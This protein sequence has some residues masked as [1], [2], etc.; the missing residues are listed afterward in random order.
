M[1]SYPSV[2][3]FTASVWRTYFTPRPVGPFCPSVR[4][5][6]SSF[7]CLSSSVLQVLAAVTNGDAAALR[8]CHT[9]RSRCSCCRRAK[10]ADAHWPNLSC[11]KTSCKGGMRRR[12]GT[13]RMVNRTMKRRRWYGAHIPRFL[14]SR[15]PGIPECETSVT[16]RSFYLLLHAAPLPPP[17]CSFHSLL[18]L[19]LTALPPHCCSCFP[20]CSSSTSSSSLLLLFASLP[21]CSCSSSTS[22]LLLPPL[23]LLTAAGPPHCLSLLPTYCSSS[24]LMLL[25][26]LK[27][28]SP[29][30]PH[31]SSPYFVLLAGWR[32]LA[33]SSHP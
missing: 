19:L 3:S 16:E 32:H 13:R 2:S 28:P 21:F 25:F 5:S 7:L 33:F 1:R 31:C 6:G 24:L 8:H 4:S 23:F 15:G 27:A 10:D 14:S 17:N 20:Y 22:S 12:A 11:S 29:P 30:P 18:H 26:L 9:A